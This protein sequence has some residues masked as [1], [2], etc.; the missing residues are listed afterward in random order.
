LIAFTAIRGNITNANV[1]NEFCKK[2]NSSYNTIKNIVWKL[3]R[4]GIFTKQN[5]KIKINPVICLDFNKP[6]T[7]QINIIDGE[8]SNDVD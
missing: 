3:K 7:L 1:R 8:A 6:L 4:Y 5:N 2:H